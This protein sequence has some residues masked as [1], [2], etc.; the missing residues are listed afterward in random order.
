MKRDSGKS[1]V[2]GFHVGV[3]RSLMFWANEIETS[4]PDGAVTNEHCVLGKHG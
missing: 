3:L 1:L 2:R 4:Y